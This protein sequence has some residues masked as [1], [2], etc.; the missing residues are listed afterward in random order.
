MPY[1][2][3]Q[4]MIDEFGE[5]QLVELTDRADPPAGTVDTALAERAIATVSAEVDGYCGGRYALPLSPV[6]PTVKS[7]VLDMA[8]YRLFTNAPPD[9]VTDRNKA[10]LAKLRDI[11][12]GRLRLSSAVAGQMA[13]GA[14]LV[15]VAAGERVFS[16]GAR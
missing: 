10:A 3:A 7:I 8:R 6:D 14:N 2:T 12:A 9:E 1:A 11:E 15:E 13:R 16:R 4:D 5:P